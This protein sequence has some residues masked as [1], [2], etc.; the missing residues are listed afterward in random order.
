[1]SGIGCGP[2]TGH[3]A[4]ARSVL[5]VEH[6][7]CSAGLHGTCHIPGSLGCGHSRTYV[8]SN[9]GGDY[10]I[11]PDGCRARHDCHH[12]H[13]A[14]GRG[15]GTARRRTVSGWSFRAYRSGG[16]RRRSSC[17]NH[18]DKP[19]GVEAAEKAFPREARDLRFVLI[20]PKAAN[21][22]TIPKNAPEYVSALTGPPGSSARHVVPG[23]HS[24]CSYLIAAGRDADGR[25]SHGANAGGDS[26]R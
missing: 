10:R 11:R 21:P 15:G 9:H 4:T 18:P 8:G 14:G 12:R 26:Q 25:N 1:M 19:Q 2:A 23:W 20:R 17:P 22:F 3:C 24:R 7:F 6:V 13:V 5:G 16:L